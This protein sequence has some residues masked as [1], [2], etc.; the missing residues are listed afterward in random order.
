MLGRR[1]RHRGLLEYID[2]SVHGLVESL[3][4]GKVEAFVISILAGEAEASRSLETRTPVVLERVVLQLRP[5]GRSEAGAAAAPPDP[6]AL[7]AQ[8]R[9]F[10]QKI[11]ACDSLYRIPLYPAESCCTSAGA[12]P[13]CANPHL[14]TT[15]NG[16]CDR[17]RIV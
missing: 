12:H 8:L 1:S 9:S 4:L 6:S 13:R 16:S 15:E 5:G 14:R 17:Y 7:Q 10:L 11:T 3:R 2:Q